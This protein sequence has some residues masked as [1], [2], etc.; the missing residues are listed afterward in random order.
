MDTARV[1]AT[2][3]IAQVLANMMSWCRIAHPQNM[4]EQGTL[5]HTV[6][7]E[8]GQTREM[9]EPTRVSLVGHTD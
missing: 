8:P 9:R 7:R 3:T 2:M 1:V 4:L 6:K 5:C